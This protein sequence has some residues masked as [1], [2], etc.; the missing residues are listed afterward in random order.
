MMARLFR[1]GVVIVMVLTASGCDMT[2]YFQRG[3]AF[4]ALGGAGIG[5][6]VGHANHNTAAGA[7]IGTGVGAVAGG[8]GGAVLD[9]SKKRADAAAQA[10]ADFD[11]G[12]ATT[13]EVLAMTRAGVDPQLIVNYVNR[14]G[15]NQPLTYQDIIY[16][17]DQG[18]SA[19]VVETMRTSRSAG[20]PAECVRVLPPRR[21]IVVGDDPW[22]PCYYPQYGVAYGYG[23]GC[24]CR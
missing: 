6:L 3:A 13:T 5:A 2:S 15:M 10:A 11:P 18:V 23:Y 12:G 19:E 14:A 21:V 24:R 17:R 22:S 1:R 9:E 8:V 4:G 7:L 20:M 16:L